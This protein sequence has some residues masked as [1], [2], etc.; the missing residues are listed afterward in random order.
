M[1]CIMIMKSIF[2]SA[3]TR[4][5]LTFG[6]NR[7]GRFCM[8]Q[9]HNDESS[10]YVSGDFGKIELGQND[11]AGPTYVTFPGYGS[12]GM[13][14]YDIGSHNKNSSGTALTGAYPFPQYGRDGDNNKFHIS[15]QIL[16]VFHSAIHTAMSNRQR[17]HSCWSFLFNRY[18]W[19]RC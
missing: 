9:T 19:C 5:G 1:T 13:G 2:H 7:N 18:G 14:S 6:A 4:Y 11:G 17:R 3:S 15:H 10:M 12:N 16:A 8:L